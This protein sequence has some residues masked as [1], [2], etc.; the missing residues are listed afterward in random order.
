MS[1]V[2]SLVVVVAVTL[3]PDSNSAWSTLAPGLS[4]SS[5][6]ATPTLLVL[7]A[8]LATVTPILSAS[9]TFN[10]TVRPAIVPLLL[11]K[12]TNTLNLSPLLLTTLLATMLMFSLVPLFTVD[13]WL[14]RVAILPLASAAEN[15][16]AKLL[17]I[18]F[19]CSSVRLFGTAIV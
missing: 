9:L 19:F 18:A 3:I 10:R 16:T 1:C 13:T 6:V 8:C 11:A 4:V 15:T 5:K 17:P 14:T 7:I 12:R 2:L